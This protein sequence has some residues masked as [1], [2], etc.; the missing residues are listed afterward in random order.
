M[1]KFT[2]V[3]QGETLRR[4]ARRNGSALGIWRNHHLNKFAVL[5][6]ARTPSDR[7]SKGDRAKETRN[8]FRRCNSKTID[9]LTARPFH[10]SAFTTFWLVQGMRQNALNKVVH[11]FKSFTFRNSQPTRAPQMFKRRLLRMPLPP[12]SALVTCWRCKITST[13]WPLKANPRKR[14]TK[15]GSRVPTKLFAPPRASLH[16]L[17]VAREAMLPMRK[18]LRWNGAC[19]M[20]P[21][22]KK[23]A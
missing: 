11:F 21:M 3:R 6:R 22:L 18:P 20:R 4:L 5:N 23:S 7:L 15:N 14:A 8:F 10:M 9:R 1:S 12:T 16:T 17:V 19:V 2:P 13:K